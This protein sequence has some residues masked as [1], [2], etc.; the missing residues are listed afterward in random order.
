MNYGLRLRI[1]CKAA[2]IPPFMD[3]RIPSPRP[4][5]RYGEDAVSPLTL[6]RWG[7]GLTIAALVTVVP[8]GY[9]RWE[10]TFSK[11]LRQVVPGRV[12]RSGQLTADGFAAAVNRF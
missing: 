10:Y 2:T 11:R 4:G 12:Y 9:Y 6:L 1:F 8:Y 3:G 5:D 7:L